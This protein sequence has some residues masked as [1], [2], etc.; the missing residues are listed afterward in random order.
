MGLRLVASE[1]DNFKVREMFE[2]KA[3]AEDAPVVKFN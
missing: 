2:A 1:E 3:G